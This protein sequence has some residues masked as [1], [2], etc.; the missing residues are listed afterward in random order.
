MAVVRGGTVYAMGDAGVV[1]ADVRI[2]DGRIER[3]ADRIEPERGEEVIEAAGLVV[4]PG[5]VDPHS[6]VGGFDG[7]A[8]DLNELTCPR[9]PELDALHG[10]DPA[11]DDFEHALAQ[12]ITTSLVIPG[13]GNVIGGWGV[14][15]KSAGPAEGRVLR[16]PAVLKAATGINPKGVYSGRQ[17]MPMTRMGIIYLLRSYLRDVRDYRER[18]RVHEEDPS[19]PAPDYDAGLEHGIPVL[20]GEMPLKVHTYMQDMT[21]VVELAREFDISVTIDHAQGASDFYDELVD[22]HVA[23]VVFGPVN[24]GL[25]PGEGGIIDYECLKGLDDRGVTV[26]VMTDGPVSVEGMLVFQMGEAVRAGMDPVR[27]LA[28]ATS[29]PAHLLGVEDR[30][31]SIEPGKDADLLLW[32]ALPTLACDARLLRVLSDGVT[33]YQREG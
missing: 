19:R 31:G 29:N 1:R 26:T 7:E 33:V 27:A 21:Q 12:G 22:P 10:I 2:V 18:K 15:I 4:T 16:H 8:Q 11:S 14:V 6:H 17:Q 23:G 20:D 9:T 5:F 32:S 24:M 13:S 3:V 30:V 25:F 28:M